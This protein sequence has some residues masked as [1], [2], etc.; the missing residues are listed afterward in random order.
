MGTQLSVFL[1]AI[2]KPARGDPELSEPD[3]N[4]F[5]TID[6]PGLDGGVCTELDLLQA[7]NHAMQA[8]IHTQAGGNYGSGNC[9]RDGCVAKVGIYAERSPHTLTCT[10]CMGLC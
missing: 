2:N 7:N 5:C 6:E 9:D 3:W 10:Y 4:G 1:I 8:S